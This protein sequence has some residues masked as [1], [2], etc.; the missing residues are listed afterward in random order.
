[1][2]KGISVLNPVDFE[3]NYLNYT[4]DYAIRKGYDH[5]QFIGPIHDVIKGNI[6]G[7]TP[8]R[9]Y[10]EFNEEKNSEYVDICLDMI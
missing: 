5:F 3:E 2:I 10:S 9:K 6:D 1:M 8:F 4:V 7:M